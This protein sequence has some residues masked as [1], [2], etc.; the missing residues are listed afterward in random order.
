LDSPLSRIAA[1]YWASF[2]PRKVATS[3][4]PKEVR[5]SPVRARNSTP[6]VRASIREA[7]EAQNRKFRSRGIQLRSTRDAHV[8]LYLSIVKIDSPVT[9]LS[10][11]EEALRRKIDETAASRREIYARTFLFPRFAARSPRSAFE[12]RSADHVDDPRLRDRSEDA[13]RCLESNRDALSALSPCADCFQRKRTCSFASLR[14]KKSS[15][16]ARRAFPTCE[17]TNTGSFERIRVEMIARMTRPIVR[18][19]SLSFTDG[20]SR[21]RFLSSAVL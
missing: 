14:R 18:P 17:T 20:S 4:Q 7:R 1:T 5:R 21:S 8:D 16:F 12:S 9:R 10:F 13:I 6:E 11:A 2:G 3:P 19:A 15:R